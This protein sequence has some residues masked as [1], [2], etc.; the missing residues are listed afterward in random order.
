[1]RW[2]PALLLV[3]LVLPGC[4]A[5][6]P[7]GG[8]AACGGGAIEPTPERV[9]RAMRFAALAP[10][11]GGASVVRLETESGIDTWLRIAV[12]LPAAGV[13]P[14]LAASG[15]A[16]DGPP[17]RLANPDGAVV[18]RDA[19]TAAVGPGLVEVTV[20]AFTT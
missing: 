20:T 14:W 17:Q 15:A 13:D 10:L 16:T 19:R 7:V 1:M 9:A 5:D 3:L 12:R 2:L 4:R 18:T 11:P 8:E 6:L